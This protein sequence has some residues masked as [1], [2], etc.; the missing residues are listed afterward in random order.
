MKSAWEEAQQLM[1][2]CCRGIIRKL[3]LLNVKT[4]ILFLGSDFHLNMGEVVKMVK[5]GL[6]VVGVVLSDN[7][8]GKLLIQ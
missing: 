3:K 2:P 5:D 1:V 7:F 4:K 6:N 8:E